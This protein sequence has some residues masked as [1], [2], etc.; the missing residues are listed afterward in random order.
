M[1]PHGSGR[2][3]QDFTPDSAHGGELLERIRR[4]W[5]I[6]GGLHQWLDVSGGEE[7]SGVHNRN[8]ILMLGILRRNTG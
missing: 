1:S 8:A 3:R 6:E 5:D 4:Y 7:A 2:S